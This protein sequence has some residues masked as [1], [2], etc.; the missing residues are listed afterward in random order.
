MH[1]VLQAQVYVPPQ[2]KLQAEHEVPQAL[3]GVPVPHIKV[4]QQPSPSPFRL[5]NKNFK[6]P[7]ATNL[8][9]NQPT[10]WPNS[11]LSKT[12]TNSSLKMNFQVFY[13]YEWTIG[14]F[15]N[16]VISEGGREEGGQEGREEEEGRWRRGKG[17]GR[18]RTEKEEEEEKVEGGEG[19]K[20][21]N[22]EK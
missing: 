16:Y 12:W 4:L 11:S 17:G 13:C 5:L 8:V 7:E 9:N 20:G 14:T 15:S 18:R 10:W 6:R 3:Q 2:P 19:R 22:G 1:Q 21:N